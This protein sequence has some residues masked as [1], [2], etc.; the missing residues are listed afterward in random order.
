MG[1]GTAKAVG[2]SLAK[3]VFVLLLDWFISGLLDDTYLNHLPIFSIFFSCGMPL[4]A[5]SKSVI[6]T[7]SGSGTIFEP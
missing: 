1:D 7:M 4:S 2:L 6:F 5:R 3:Q